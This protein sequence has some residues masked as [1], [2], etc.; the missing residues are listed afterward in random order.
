MDFSKPHIYRRQIIATGKYYIGKHNGSNS[1]Y[2][3]GSGVDYLIDYKKYINDPKLDLIEEILEYI[4]DIS[5][6]NEREEYW[7]KK[8]DVASNPLFYNKTNR[9]R[10]WS[11]LTE[12]QKNKIRVSHLGKKQSNESTQKKREKMLGKP[13]HSQ[14]SK[15]KIGLKNK[16]PK[17]E[18]FKEK[19]QKHKSEEHCKNLSKA[20][21]IPIL[22]YDLKGNFIKEWESGKKAADSLNLNQGC[23]N[24][25]IRG[26]LKKSGGYKWKYK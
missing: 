1:K 5:K 11:V 9:S 26:K 10:G 7:L 15:N 19:C 24:D 6:I 21:S 22:Q 13:K 3:K 18:G 8:F 4:E 25:A 16:H 12:E 23:I 14:E 2:Y 17:P 20:K